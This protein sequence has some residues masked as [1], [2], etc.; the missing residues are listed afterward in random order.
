MKQFKGSPGAPGICYASAAVLQAA[1]GQVTRSLDEAV[2]ACLE[3]V[4][5][6][7]ATTLERLGQEDAAIF[8][9]YEMLLMDDY[10]LEPIRESIAQGEEPIEAVEVC[11][12]QQ[13]AAFAKAKSEYM[14]QR[15]DDIRNLKRMLQQELRGGSTPLVLPEDNKSFVL[16]AESLSPADTMQVDTKRLAGLVTRYGGVTSHVVILAKSLGIP[17]VTGVQECSQILSGQAVAANGNTGEIL[18]EP[19]PGALE[20]VARD[21]QGQERFRRMLDALPSGELAMRDGTPVHVSINIGLCGDLDGVKLENIHGVGL[22]RTEFLFSDC[23]EKPT[24][25]QQTEEYQRVFDALG[26]KNLIVRTLDIGGDKVI[27]YLDIPKEENPFLGCRGIRLCMRNETIFREQLEALLTAASGRPFQIM[28]PMVDTVAEFLWAKSIFTEIRNELGLRGIK[29]DQQI[30]LGIMV[31]T[32]AAVFSAPLFAK[33]VDFVSIGTNDLTQ[34]VLAADRGNPETGVTLSHYD[35][36]VIRA[37]HYAIE[38][39]TDAKIKVSVCGEAGSDIKF[40]PVLAAMGLRYVSVSPSMVDSV[41]Y[42][43]SQMDMTQASAL[44]EEVLSMETEAE[45]RECLY[46]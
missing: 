32:P 41:R 43:V 28:F 8:E 23:R 45:I 39:Y 35:P 15:A 42:T 14:R 25:R 19:D 33:H 2:Q 31:E 38:T 40:L 46:K 7:Q 18:V 29:T 11:M 26:G 5:K 13:A 16:V 36:A 27:P 3:T 9:A 34:Y 4:K 20:K 30:Q 6:L 21:I 22:Y 44:L 24:V 1:S 10:L 37:L 12:E 17:A